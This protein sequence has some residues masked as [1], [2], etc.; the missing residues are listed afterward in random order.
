MA[1]STVDYD[2][3]VHSSTT[4]EPAALDNALSSLPPELRVLVVEQHLDE[5]RSLL[6]SVVRGGDDNAET[7]AIASD[8]PCPLLSLPSELLTLVVETL[9]T[10]D[11]AHLVSRATPP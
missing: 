8:E 9:E 4:Y 2:D 7:P 1:R 5:K 10:L 3:N 6:A 11:L